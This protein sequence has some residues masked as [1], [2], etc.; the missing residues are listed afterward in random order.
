MQQLL[1]H[2]TDEHRNEFANLLARHMLKVTSNP[3]SLG[4]LSLAVEVCDAE[5]C[6]NLGRVIC[7]SRGILV[8]IAQ[9]RHGHRVALSALEALRSSSTE[10]ENA[11]CQLQSKRD[12]L[13]NTRYGRR[14]LTLCERDSAQLS[15]D[16]VSPKNIAELE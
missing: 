11:Y 12:T 2:G 13:A 14:V 15:D 10:Y 8:K 4:V 3:S 9:Q 1:T 7:D 5:Q 16:D 6:L